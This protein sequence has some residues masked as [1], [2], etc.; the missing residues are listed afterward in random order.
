[1]LEKNTRL[2]S[3]EQVKSF[4]N[5]AMSKEF[6]VDLYSGKYIV[7]GKSIMG[8]FSIDLTKPIKMV[9]T[10]DESDIFANEIES[11]VCQEKN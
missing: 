1:M 7:N 11:F 3:I 6:D 9:A 2:G 8:I 5:L 4:V 10:C